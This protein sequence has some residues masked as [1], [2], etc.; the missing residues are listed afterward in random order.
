M[1]ELI[2]LSVFLGL[3]N[4][5]I[6]QNNGMVNG[7]IV[8]E[9]GLSLPGAT[10]VL[11]TASDS[12]LV[13]FG[14]TN[15]EGQFGFQA[16]PHDDYLF[17]ASFVGLKGVSQP[18]TISAEA[19]MVPLGDVVLT[20]D[21]YALGEVAIEESMP[22]LIKKDT[23]EY[24]ADSFRT[25]EGDN[26]EKLLKKLP[27]VQVD[28]D[29]N[30][31]AQGEEV[32]KVFVDG[33]EFFGDDPKMATQ[34]LPA[35]AVDK[36]QVY[37]KKSDFAEFTGLDDGSREKA[38]NLTLKEDKK[39]GVFGEVEAGL[40]T[41]PS[42]PLKDDY[43]TDN[44][45]NV[46]R[47]DKKAQTSVLGQ[48]NNINRQ[49]FSFQDYFNFAGGFDAM[50]GTLELS[51]DD[52]PVPL[53]FGDDKGLTTTYALGGNFNREFSK[54]TDLQSSAFYSQM[55]KGVT[56][57][58][59][60][61]YV[62]VSDGYNSTSSYDDRSNNENYR[63]NLRLEH[64]PDSSSRFL[65]K[66]Q[67]RFNNFTSTGIST[68][69]N[70]DSQGNYLSGNTRNSSSDR[71]LWTASGDA[72]YSKKLAKLGRVLSFNAKSRIRSNDNTSLLFS[73]NE[74]QLADELNVDSLNQRQQSISDLFEYEAGFSYTEP[75]NVNSY[76]QLSGKFSEQKNNLNKQFFDIGLDDQPETLN[77]LLSNRFDNTISTREGGANINFRGEK[78]HLTVGSKY[79]ASELAGIVA[80]SI[81]VNHRYNAIRPE[82]FFSYEFSRTSRLRANFNTRLRIPS[83]QE[84]QPIIDNS[85]PLSIYMGNPNLQAETNYDLNF[86]YML[87]SQ[88]SFT[89][90]NV[91]A[92]ASYV[93]NKIV[94]SVTVDSNLVQTIRPINTDNQ[95]SF[96]GSM[97][98]DTPIKPIEMII[99][100]GPDASYSRSFVF[101]NGVDDQVDRLSFGGELT[102]ENRYKENLD[103]VVGAYGEFT[104]TTYE[105]ESAFNQ[106]YW[107]IEYFAEV[108]FDFGDR[109]DLGL[110]GTLEMYTG[111]QVQDTQIL[112]LEGYLSRNFLESQ[113]LTLE[114]RAF[115]VLNQRQGIFRASNINYI[116]EEFTNTL[117]R[118]VMFSAQWR[119]SKF[120]RT[121]MIQ[122]S[123]G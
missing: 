1:R 106:D 34:N 57:N 94:S 71:T 108:E 67:A 70:T 45:L 36:V 61:Q 23:V 72:S 44:R 25:Q 112:L 30:I 11:I 119:L 102:L 15:K 79:Q 117:G 123:E 5:A 73:I 47:F 4:C 86:N 21:A 122:F 19:N 20:A 68:G 43:R 51:E 101:V 62:A 84:L 118:Y 35:N 74:I 9:A 8:D 18:I 59:S 121:G 3:V 109:W 100:L 46:N 66:G 111:N 114:V 41:D 16:V 96:R 52:L 56:S 13:Q 104:R 54:K 7:R 22:I 33:K 110:E 12:T 53:D 98:F 107:L 31:K 82:G 55:D 89:G 93:D 90:L 60:R 63:L 95:L 87:Y 105:R 58:S 116:E 42:T 64:K 17:Q 99:G 75:V 28:K 27:G 115:D 26:V 113:R 85:N 80:D 65:I 83:I 103:W 14:I 76:V 97:S 92:G 78:Y 91:N 10:V 6:A 40:G 69:N 32:Q 29:G 120:K 2:L 49:G 50:G 77:E 88:F 38:I 39:K 81:G 48:M 37:D 24:N